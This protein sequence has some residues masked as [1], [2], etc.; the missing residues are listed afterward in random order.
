MKPFFYR[1]ENETKNSVFKQNDH[2]YRSVPV[3]LEARSFDGDRTD[4]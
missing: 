2:L 3:D 4:R 1:P